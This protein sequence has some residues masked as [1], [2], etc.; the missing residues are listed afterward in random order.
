MRRLLA[1]LLV[2]ALLVSIAPPAAHAGHAHGAHA[3]AVG[4]SALLFAP[5]LIAG[6]IIASVVPPYRPVVPAP[7]VV[8]PPPA[9]RV[10]TARYVT[11]PVASAS[12]ASGEVNVVRYPHGRYVLHGDGVTT[13]YQW[14]WIPNPPPPPPPPPART[15]SQ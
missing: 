3:V 9:Y 8:A 2:A 1:L 14:V 13:P 11:T 5:F 6:G 7:V 10:E 15:V 4:I 12:S